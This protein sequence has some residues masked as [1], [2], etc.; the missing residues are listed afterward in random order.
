MYFSNSDNQ[1]PLFG[2]AISS[3]RPAFYGLDT[4]QKPNVTDPN[5][6]NDRVSSGKTSNSR[7]GTV[8]QARR[9]LRRA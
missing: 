2:V 1:Y 4:L 5:K 6:Y 7:V 9:A 3:L 8:E